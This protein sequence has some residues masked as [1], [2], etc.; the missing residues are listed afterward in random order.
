VEEI[1]EIDRFTMEQQIMCAW[2][3]CDDIET[4]LKAYM[5]RP[6]MMSEDELSNL[7]IGLKSMHQLRCEQLFDTF[8]KLIRK[9]DIK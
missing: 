9:G 8:E 1:K 3:T 6:A 5:D 4:I 2:G 7:L